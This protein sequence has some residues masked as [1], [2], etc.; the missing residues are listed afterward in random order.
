MRMFLTFAAPLLALATASSTTGGGGAMPDPTREY[1]QNVDCHNSYDRLVSDM[2]AGV[3][4]SPAA[5]AWAVAHEASAEAKTPCA[6]P[7][8]EMVARGGNWHIRTV[9]GRNVAAAYAFDQN[10]PAA[11]SEIGHALINGTV[12]GGTPQE[13]LALVQQAAE[14]GDPMALYSVGTLHAA[15]I[16]DG[17][18]DYARAFA[19]LSR[20][21][22][23]G[24]IDAIYRTGLHHSEGLGTKKD[25]KKAFEA[26]KT[27]AERGHLYSTI[28]AFDMIVGGKGVKQDF[29]LAYRLA[30]IVAEQGEPYGAVMAASS[31][32]QMK[33]ALK[34]ED[35]IL[36]WMD[37]GIAKGDAN[38]RNTLIPLKQQVAGIFTKAKAPPQY[39]PRVRKACPMKTVCYVN[40]HSGLRSCTTNKDYWSDCDW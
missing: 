2:Q 28:M 24:H 40:Q 17:K 1:H 6:P 11:L 8:P 12:E 20:A 13:G 27:A 35:E 34:H 37:L 31:L 19:L 16:L 39:V 7:L 15:G 25:P 10:D 32:L 30:R 3:A 38:I 21:A 29:K 18:K 14:L 23:A 4:I 33:D 22:E 5:R 9:P 36:Y 26:F